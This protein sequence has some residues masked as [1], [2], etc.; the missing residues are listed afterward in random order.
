[1][2]SVG[3]GRAPPGTGR[4]KPLDGNRVVADPLIS[5]RLNA[6]WLSVD[7]PAAGAHSL[8]RAS[9]HHRRMREIAID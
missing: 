4:E 7:F 2:I 8:R 5:S 1:M 3:A 6:S 9:S